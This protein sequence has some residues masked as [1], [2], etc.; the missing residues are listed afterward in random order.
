MSSEIKDKLT[1]EMKS[2]MKSKQ[3]ERLGV[4]RALLAAVKQK[5]V[6][7]RIEVDDSMLLAILDKQLKQR[8]ESAKIYREAS[9]DE[10]AENEEFEITVIQD[11]LPQALTEEEISAIISEAINST[12]ASS[13]KD[14][15]KVMAQ[16]KPQIQGKADM[17]EVSKSIKSQ[18]S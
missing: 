4:I 1:Q 6:D 12:G 11:F 2:A 17:G 16:I 14:M 5:E 9:R 8:K 18:L 13:M 3:K 7:E 15:G 10:L